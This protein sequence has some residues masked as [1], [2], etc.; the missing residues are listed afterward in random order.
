[1]YRGHRAK[2]P[3]SSNILVKIEISPGIFKKYSDIELHEKPLSGGGGDVPCGRTDKKLIV[4]FRS[5][6]NA[7]KNP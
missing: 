7:P 3:H 1:M 2:Y 6:A 4:V 5:F